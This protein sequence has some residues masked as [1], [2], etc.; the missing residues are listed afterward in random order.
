MVRSVKELRLSKQLITVQTVRLAAQGKRLVKQQGPNFA[1]NL[2]T[3]MRPEE[4][5]SHLR[6]AEQYGWDASNNAGQ[7]AGNDL[8]AQIELYAAVVKGRSAEVNERLGVSSEV[9]RRQRYDA[10]S[11][12]AIKLEKIRELRLLKFQESLTFA[13]TWTKRLEPPIPSQPAPAYSPPTSTPHPAA[14]A[15]SS[16]TPVYSPPCNDHVYRSRARHD[17]WCQC[18][19]CTSIGHDPWC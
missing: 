18:Q 13:E 14:P 17:P 6:G 4:K 16:T 19:R 11:E 3:D 12:T 10:L 15:C 8:L 2:I 7:S 5:L 1:R 9:I